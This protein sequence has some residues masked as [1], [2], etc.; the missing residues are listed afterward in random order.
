MSDSIPIH[1]TTEDGTTATKLVSTSKAELRVRS[2]FNPFHSQ[3]S[4]L[5]NSLA[6]NSSSPSLT[7]SLT[8]RSSPTS[9]CA[10]PPPFFFLPLTLLQL[11]HNAFTQIPP[12]VLTMTKLTYLNVRP[13]LL[14]SASLTS[15]SLPAAQRQPIGID[16]ARAVPPV[17]A[18]GA[19]REP[20]PIV[21]APP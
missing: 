9:T 5:A 7:M 18:H 16:S 1:I 15:F 2:F 3:A 14:P 21:G 17:R 8:S 12:A 19:S 11:H 20:Q 4:P 13:P 10:S 6:T